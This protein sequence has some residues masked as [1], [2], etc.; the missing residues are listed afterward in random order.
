LV[1]GATGQE[2]GDPGDHHE[3]AKHER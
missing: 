1:G 3:R 2:R